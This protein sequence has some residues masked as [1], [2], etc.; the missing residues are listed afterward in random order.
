[1]EEDTNL[2]VRR[3]RE[4]GTVKDKSAVF[5]CKEVSHEVHLLCDLS[6]NRDRLWDTEQI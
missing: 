2:K 6:I 1:M 3:K 4:R 5:S